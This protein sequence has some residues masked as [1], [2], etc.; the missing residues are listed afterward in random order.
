VISSVDAAVAVIPIVCCTEAVRR[1][2][3][4]LSNSNASASWCH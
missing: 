4:V 3:S 2:C 1:N